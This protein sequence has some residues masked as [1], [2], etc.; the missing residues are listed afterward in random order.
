MTNANKKD[1]KNPL[2]SAKS[3][4]RTI[5]EKLAV[6][7]RL[8]DLQRALAPIAKQIELTAPREKLRFGSRRNEV[9]RFVVVDHLMFVG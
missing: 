3:A 5:A 1:L 7:E 4:K 8:R 2:M 9:D 6:A